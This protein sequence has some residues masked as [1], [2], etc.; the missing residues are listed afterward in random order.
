MTTY[1]RV[2]GGTVMELFTPPDGTDIAECFA[3]GLT[4]QEC[5]PGVRAHWTWD[6]TAFAPPAYDPAMVTLGVAPG[7]PA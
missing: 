5:G 4:W 1:A 3:P 6:G 7:A 2:Q